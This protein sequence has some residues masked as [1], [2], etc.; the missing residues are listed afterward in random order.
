MPLAC[1]IAGDA[2]AAAA[3]QQQQRLASGAAAAAGKKG[4][5][6]SPPQQQL[7]RPPAKGGRWAATG[8]GGEPARVLTAEELAARERNN[9]LLAGTLLG[10]A[11][12]GYYMTTSSKRGSG[13]GKAPTTEH[14][15]NWS[16]THECQV[17]RY[18]QPESLEELEGMVKKAHET[19][20]GVGWWGRAGLAVGSGP[21]PA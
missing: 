12:V 10:M 19:G 5:R 11:G 20:A 3:P 9:I 15:V 13:A 18:Y 8:P 7:Y 14:L 1:P 17:R 6:P 2:A 21:Q 16:G 4:G